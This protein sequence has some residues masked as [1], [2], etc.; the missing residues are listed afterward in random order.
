MTNAAFMA[1]EIGTISATSTSSSL[2]FTAGGI[3]V[4]TLL[5]ENTGSKEAFVRWGVGAQTAVTTD[6]SVPSGAIMLFSKAYDANVVAAICAGSD[7]TT[8]R[9]SAGEGN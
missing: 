7:T 6:Q 3:G 5:I 4:G 1:T 9:I 2:T 8:L